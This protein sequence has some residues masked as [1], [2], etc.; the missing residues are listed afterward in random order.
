[1]HVTQLT[2]LMPSMVHLIATTSHPLISGVLVA[3]VVG[4]RCGGRRDVCVCVVVVVG[5][6]EFGLVVP[7]SSLG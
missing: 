7:R 4:G 1:M 5:W 6:G 2:A 3:V